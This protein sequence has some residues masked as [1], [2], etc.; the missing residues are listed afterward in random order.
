MKLNQNHR[1]AFLNQLEKA[2]NDLETEKTCLRQTQPNDPLENWHE[3][4]IFIQ[5][6][7]IDLI[8]KSL[9][10]NEIDF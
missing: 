7:K 2:Q 8:K 6:Q 1:E 10:E 3:V 4:S 5:E 9:I